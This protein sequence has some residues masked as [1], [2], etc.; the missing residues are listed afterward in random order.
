MEGKVSYGV[1]N[2]LSKHA[3]NL[4]TYE[5]VNLG[6]MYPGINVQLRATG[7]NVEKIFTVAPQRDPTQI[8]IKLA[9]ANKLEI[10][11]KGELI[12][13]TGNGP[14]T[15]TAPI[16][17]QEI[18]NGDRAPVAVAYVLNADQQRYGFTLGH[19]DATRPLIID[20]LL[21]STYHGGNANENASALAIHPATG[22]VYVVGYTSST[23]LPG[24][25]GGAQSGN[26]AVNDA[27]VSRFSL[28]LAGPG[29]VPNPFTFASRL[30]VPISSLQTS[31]ATQISGVVGAVPVS[32]TGGNFGEY[33]VSSG[34]ACSCDVRP[35]ASVAATLNN[36]QY[37]C[38]RQ[39]APAFTPGQI[40][41]TLVVGGGWADFIVS[42][43][44]Q[45]TSCNLDIDGSGG[46][47][48]PVSDGLMLVRAMLGFTGTAVTNGAITG[49]PPRNTWPL[50]RDYLNQNCGTNFAP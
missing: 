42:T 46:A 41:T 44:T 2:D 28:D 27:F 9:G 24:V 7:N 19:Y 3:D 43:G 50:I 32:I 35:F 48:N 5:R 23:D 34:A 18:A 29:V 21:Q 49:S 1:G 17:F 22:E 15:F 38:V 14:V 10:G 37:V 12:A 25:A 8:K 33:C 26:S 30:N 11:N 20:P 4:N 31:N 36:N 45:I 13:H 39:V 6:D 16:A 40:K 47:P